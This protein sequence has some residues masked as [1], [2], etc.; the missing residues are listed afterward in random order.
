MQNFFV[1]N[2]NIILVSLGVFVVSMTTL[3][4]FLNTGGNLNSLND[5]KTDVIS[6]A[7]PEATDQ[8]D[9]EYRDLFQNREDPFLLISLDGSVD[10]ASGNFETATGLNPKDLKDQTYF[11]FVNPDDLPIVLSAFGK[12]LEKGEVES[13]I[14]P[15]KVLDGNGEYYPIKKDDKVIAV[16]I[17][18]RDIST[19]VK[20]VSPPA[21]DTTPANVNG[22]SYSKKLLLKAKNN[23]AA[24]SGEVAE[25]NVAVSAEQN[26]PAT[27]SFENSGTD[28]ASGFNSN[29]YKLHQDD[30]E[31]TTDRSLDRI[32]KPVKD[33][34]WIMSY[35]PSF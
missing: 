29:V 8:Q 28:S 15:Y 18:N 12:T 5:L 2:R 34:K 25:N 11:S 30:P 7:F 33:T 23:V 21:T 35:N 26:P 31:D 16:G 9:K 4:F 22:N 10:Y 14:G 1:Q 32:R 3:L 27:N 20:D 17:V 13:M 24:G 19:A 6:S